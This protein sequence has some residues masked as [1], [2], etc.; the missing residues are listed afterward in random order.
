MTPLISSVPRTSPIKLSSDMCAN[1]TSS[2]II[3]LGQV[4]RGIQGDIGNPV[5]VD[6][7]IKEIQASL[8][9]VTLLV[10]N[11]GVEGEVAPI[12]STEE[13]N[14][15]FVL[16]VNVKGVYFGLKHV[17]P[18][19]YAQKRGSVI[20]TA[21]VAGLIGSPGLAPYIA[22]KHAVLGITKT[23]ALES[24]EFNVRVNAVCPGPV[25]NNMMRNIEKKASPQDP[26]VVKEA[27]EV[28]IP[29]GKYATNL[30]VANVIL[31][32]ASNKTEYIT[33]TINR[34]DGGM[35]AK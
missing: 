27:Q 24:A 13:K 20:I 15:D 33:G 23:A 14:L 29:F 22:S 31:F 32:L 3:S 16:D 26:K 30:D 6:A 18:V 21:S 10:N 4:A 2:E 35:G 8:G 12:V 17:L 5:T 1:K 28:A 7:M 34:V 25:D 11:A 9:D 19:M